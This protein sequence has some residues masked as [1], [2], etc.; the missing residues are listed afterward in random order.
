MRLD[1]YGRF[2]LD[3]ERTSSG[4]RVFELGSEGK[5]RTREDIVLPADLPEADVE[6]FIDDLLHEL[7]APGRMVRRMDGARSP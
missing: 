2:Q 4:Y 1:V 6:Q 7:G 3:I 5:R